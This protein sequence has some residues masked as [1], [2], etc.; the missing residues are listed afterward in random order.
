FR[1]RCPACS[2]FSVSL[3]AR[4]KE[5]QC[6][7]CRR[8]LLVG[9]RGGSA[10]APVHLCSYL[11]PDPSLQCLQ[12]EAPARVVVA[13]NLALD[14]LSL[15]PGEL[16]HQLMEFPLAA[17]LSDADDAIA[18]AQLPEFMPAEAAGDEAK[19]AGEGGEDPDG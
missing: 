2:D 13:W 1:F 9:D 18:A 12:I 6:P 17:D 7:V 3:P 15:P 14:R 16:L 5:V 19:P 4:P 8:L 11:V 10:T